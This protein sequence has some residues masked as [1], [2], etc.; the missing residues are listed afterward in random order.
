MYN[1]LLTDVTVCEHYTCII[2]EVQCFKKNIIGVKCET[3]FF[4]LSLYIIMGTE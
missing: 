4:H 1:Y 3:V 2:T